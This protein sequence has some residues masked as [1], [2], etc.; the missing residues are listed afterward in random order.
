[1]TPTTPATGGWSATLLDS[2]VASPGATDNC[3]I[4]AGGA[5]TPN[6]VVTAEGVVGCWP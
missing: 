3:G 2:R 5:T 6:A 4:Y 1:V